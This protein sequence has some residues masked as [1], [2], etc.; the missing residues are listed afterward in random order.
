MLE[1]LECFGWFA[2]LRAPE[3]HAPRCGAADD[4]FGGIDTQGSVEAP[5]PW[6][7]LRNG[8][9]VVEGIAM[10]EFSFLASLRHAPCCRVKDF[11]LTRLRGAVDVFF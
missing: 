3:R 10:P 8:V 11:R 7:V 2:T 1:M 5:Q 4:Y 9:A 6:A